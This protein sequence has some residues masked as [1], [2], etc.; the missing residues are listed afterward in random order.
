MM[1]LVYRHG[2][3]EMADLVGIPC[4]HRRGHA[5]RDEGESEHVPEKAARERHGNWHYRACRQSSIPPK[6]AEPM[7]AGAVSSSLE[8]A[9]QQV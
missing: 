3:A 7:L 1:M 5:E 2:I 6:P 9:V 8:A 4:G